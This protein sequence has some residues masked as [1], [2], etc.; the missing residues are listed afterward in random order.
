MKKGPREI[1]TLS[2]P[3][4]NHKKNPGHSGKAPRFLN[5]SL[6]KG[7]LNDTAKNRTKQRK[8]GM[9]YNCIP[10]GLL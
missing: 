2:R 7:F 1:A 8:T 5:P 6:Q 10:K 9:S 3:Q 4:D